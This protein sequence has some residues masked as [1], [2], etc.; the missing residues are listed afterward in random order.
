MFGL[1][2]VGSPSLWPFIFYR[3]VDFLFEAKYYD[4]IPCAYIEV[5]FK[6]TW[7]TIKTEALKNTIIKDEVF[8]I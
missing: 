1:R 8:T 7:A 4:Y 5:N 2:T 6:V 3:A